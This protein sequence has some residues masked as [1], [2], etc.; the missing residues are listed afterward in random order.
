MKNNIG[1]KLIQQNVVGFHEKYFLFLIK[2]PEQEQS[3][4]EN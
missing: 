1:I 2:R 4:R 3:K